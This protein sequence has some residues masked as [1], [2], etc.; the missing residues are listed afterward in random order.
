MN[1]WRECKGSCGHEQ[2][3]A[4]LARIATAFAKTS[5]SESCEPWVASS[6][7]SIHTYVFCAP[8]Y[9]L[10]ETGSGAALNQQHSSVS[11]IDSAVTGFRWSSRAS[12]GSHH[13]AELALKSLLGASSQL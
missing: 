4:A 1:E 7:P 5:E 3:V 12:R 13:W 2:R 11:G 8:P 10:G 6:L 9:G